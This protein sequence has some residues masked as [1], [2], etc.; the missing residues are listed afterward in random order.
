M[1]GHTHCV[2]S[3]RG[4]RN[5]WGEKKNT[6]QMK[7]VTHVVYIRDIAQF[8][9]GSVNIVYVHYRGSNDQPRSTQHVCFI[10][11]NVLRFRTS[12][13][14]CSASRQ[15][16]VSRIRLHVY[17]FIYLFLVY[18]MTPSVDWIT[19]RRIIISRSR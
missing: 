18:L 14:Q 15:A 9:H 8:Q 5:D 11:R 12:V 4:N 17:L 13:S 6:I 16:N 7:R 19:W 3:I 10:Y 1:K 2:L